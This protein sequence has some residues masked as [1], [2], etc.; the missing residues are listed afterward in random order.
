MNETKKKYQPHE[1]VLKLEAVLSETTGTGQAPITADDYK[2]HMQGWQA[3]VSGHQPDEKGNHQY[4]IGFGVGRELRTGYAT[5][6]KSRV[7]STVTNMG[8]M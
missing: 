2:N 5:S 3:G 6:L 7:A 4:R 1:E 8:Q